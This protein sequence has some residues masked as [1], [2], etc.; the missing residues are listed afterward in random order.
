MQKSIFIAIS[1]GFIF[2]ATMFYASTAL[3]LLLSA[4]PMLLQAIIIGVL[5]I[6]YWLVIVTYGLRHHQRAINIVMA[7]CDHWQYQARSGKN[8]QG[9]L[10]VERS[11]CNSLVIILYIRHLHYGRYIIIP[12]DS[13]SKHNYSFLAYKLICG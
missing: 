6:D 12:R 3:A 9:T 4:I 2:V 1:P 13:I 10:V 11:F 7:D 8:Y 5:A